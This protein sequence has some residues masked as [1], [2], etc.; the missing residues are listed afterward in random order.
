MTSAPQASLSRT[1]LRAFFLR[2]SALVVIMAVALA[3]W[4][5]HGIVQQA[6]REELHPAAA[7]VVFG[8]AEY[9]GR[10]SPV[11]RARLDHAYDLFQRGLAPLVITTGGSGKDPSFS[12]GGVGRDYLIHRGIPEEQLIAETLGNDTAESAERVAHILRTNGLQDCLA[13]S[14]EYHLYRIKAMLESN[15]IHAYAAPR[16]GSKPHTTS[17][18]AVAVLRETISYLVWR[19]H[20]T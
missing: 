15:G 10:P 5:A 12:E 18:R 11:Y 3:T 19:V 9:V 20:L 17:L 4:V 16:P 13:V 8:A 6:S 2:I 7:I 14:D 1:R